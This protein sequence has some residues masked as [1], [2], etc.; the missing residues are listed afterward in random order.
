M[1]LVAGAAITEFVIQSTQPYGDFAVGKY[2]RIE[3]EAL[4]ELSPTELIPGLDKAPR[5]ARGLVVYSTPV[6]LIIPESPLTG[7]GNLLIDVP[8][9][10]RPISHGL[11]NSP[12]ARPLAIGS[13]DQ[14]NGFLQNRGWSVAVVHWEQGEGPVFPTF[15]DGQGGKL[16]AEGVGFAAVRDITLF[17]RDARTSNPLAGAIERTYGV[18]YSQTGR[19]LKSF[20]LNGFNQLDDKLVFD[21]LHITQAGAGQLPLLAAGP[22]PGSVAWQTPGHTEPELRGVHE[23]PFT[24][25][26]VMKV[27]QTKY[28]KLPRVVVSHAYNDYLGGR[29]ALTRTGAKGIVDLPMPENVRMFDISGSPHINGRDKNPECTEAP[30]QIDWAPAVRAQLV[31]LDEW[32]QGQTPPASRLFDLEARLNDTEVFQAP[33]FLAGAIVMVPKRDVDGNTMSGVVL[34]DVAVPIASHGY[35]NAPL[36]VMACRQ[37]GTYRP[38]AKTIADRKPDDTR[39]ALDVR[40]PGGVN[41]YL[42]KIRVVT[43]ALVAERLLLAEDAVVIENA[44]A[45]NTAFTPTTPRA[46]GATTAR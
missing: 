13:L 8:N 20:L 3:A 9:R 26:D 46:R 15:F 36:T 5:N 28:R 38:F 33:N 16:Y 41:E 6:T 17:L 24:Y 22:G 34:P 4:G 45:E 27:A 35:M 29:A 14:G 7:N 11:Y 1:P 2:L 39:V 21:G 19:F 32:V 42:T 25:G 40:Y 10:G 44:A 23:E 18:G 31:A 37:S 12:R 30:G 43:R